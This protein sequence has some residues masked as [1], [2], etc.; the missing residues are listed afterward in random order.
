MQQAFINGEMYKQREKARIYPSII[1]MEQDTKKITFVFNVPKGLSPDTFEKGL[2]VF[3]QHFNEYL[4]LEMNE[5]RGILK[6]Y[7]KGLPTKLKYKYSGISDS[8][9]KKRLPIICGMN[10]EGDI[11]SFD[12]VKFPH[13]LIAGETGSG[14]S[15]HIRALL[16]TLIKTKGPKELRLVLGD[17]KRSEFHL[18]K[19]IE[20]VEGVYHSAIE[21]KPALK[22]VQREMQRRG[23][24][25][26]QEGVTSIDKLQNKFPYI[27]VCIDE[28][29][30]LKKE[31][32]IMDILEEISSIGRSLGVF[33]ILS[34][35]RPDSKL[36]EGKLKVNLTV[37]MGF[38]TADKSNSKII[39][40][41]GAENIVNPGR[42]MLKVNSSLQEIQSPELDEEVAKDLLKPH[43]TSHEK[44][45]EVIEEQPIQEN[46]EKVVQLFNEQKR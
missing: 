32:D 1:K 6:V 11:F 2:F 29:V 33:V 21:L 8:L 22:K 40:V 41:E 5:K 26:D 15:S 4:D 42:M 37:R 10:L 34:M 28:V 14:K 23:D 44:P 19:Q 18:F 3:K 31:T 27:I 35:Q 13:V 25:L 12:L 30:L 45:I 36:L 43:K 46:Y 7:K 9:K 24:M 20:H 17:L 38:K 16:T 39:G